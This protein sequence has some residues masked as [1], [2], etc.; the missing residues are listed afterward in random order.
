MREIHNNYGGFV[1]N[2]YLIQTRNTQSVLNMCCKLSF[3]KSCLHIC[4]LPLTMY[5]ACQCVRAVGSVGAIV[6]LG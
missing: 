4:I 5:T 2:N 1:H 3:L 6:C